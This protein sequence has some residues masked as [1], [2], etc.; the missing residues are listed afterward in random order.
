MTAEACLARFTQAVRD[1]RRGD[2]GKAKSLV[3]S[4]SEK[5]GSRQGEIAKKELWA[6]IKSERWANR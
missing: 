2:F 4:V 6:A 3:E 1:G 5:H